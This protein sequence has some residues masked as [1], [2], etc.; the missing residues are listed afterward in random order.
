MSVQIDPDVEA[1]IREK[2]DTGRYDDEHQ[3]LREA[4]QALDERDRL[5]DPRASLVRAK[6]EVDRGEY[7]EWSPDFM[8]QLSQ[9]ADELAARGY[10]PN[11]DVCQLERL[12]EQAPSSCSA[13]EGLR[14]AKPGPSAPGPR[15]DDATAVQGALAVV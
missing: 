6:E 12:P 5:R 8:E 15:G 2:I 1:L 7:V 9:E 14:Q 11:P 13:L 4:L 10:Q 3:V